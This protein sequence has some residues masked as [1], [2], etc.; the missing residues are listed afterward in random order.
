MNTEDPWSAVHG[1]VRRHPE[2]EQGCRH[3][4]AGDAAAAAACFETAEQQSAPDDVYSNLYTAARGYARALLNDPAALNLCRSAARAERYDGDVHEYL[5]KA[6]LHLQHRK[7]ACEAI[8]RGLRADRTHAGLRQLRR[9]MGIRRP[10]V[11]G[12]LSRDNPLNRLI[13]RLT[14]R[15][16]AGRSGPRKK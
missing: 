9:Q 12:F 7:Q 6:E 4:A 8:V 1:A 2:Y 11:L 15:R 3:L 13:G 10:P 5:A 14:Y 16:G